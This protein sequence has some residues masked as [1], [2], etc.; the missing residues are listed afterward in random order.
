M[1][2]VVKEITLPRRVI[3][4]PQPHLCPQGD[5]GACVLAGVFGADGPKEIYDTYCG[6]E[7]KSLGFCE[8]QNIVRGACYGGGP[9]EAYCD[10]PPLWPHA[11]S[12]MFGA[13]GL[14]SWQQQAPWA[15]YIE[16]AI[17]GGYYALAMV[18]H[19]KEGPLC[20][21]PNHW[22]AIVGFRELRVPNVVDGVE[23]S[24][25]YE[26][27][28]LVSCSSATTPD[29]EW[30]GAREFLTARGGFNVILARPR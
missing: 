18:S 24:A 6:L 10:H 9:V 1:T 30:V 19:G 14:P 20:A 4:Q 27:E 15:H 12:E 7:P 13:W 2:T 28:V 17:R 23:R 21:G 8:V 11:T 25:H 29:E 16:L 3:P 5:C 26:N 22:V